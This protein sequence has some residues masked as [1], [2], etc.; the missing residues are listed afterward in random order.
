M[1]VL[2]GILSGISFWLANDIVGAAF[3]IVSGLYFTSMSHEKN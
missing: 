2:T 3:L 1:G